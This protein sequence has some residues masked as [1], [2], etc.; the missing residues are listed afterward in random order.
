VAG[1]SGVAG[2]FGFGHAAP[3]AVGL[4]GGEGVVTAFGEDGAVVADLF[5]GVLASGADA[6]AFSVGGE[7]HVGVGAAAGGEMLPVLVDEVVRMVEHGGVG[8]FRKSNGLSPRLLWS[9]EVCA[10]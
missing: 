1:A 10:R 7:E 2:A 8:R 6:A 3:N 9:A 5:G 4:G